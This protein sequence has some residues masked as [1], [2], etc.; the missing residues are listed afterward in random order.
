MICGKSSL[1][2]LTLPMPQ[3]LLYLVLV[4]GLE[5]ACMPKKSRKPPCRKIVLRL[6]DLDHTKSAVINSLSSPDSRR[7]YKFSME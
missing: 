2:S 6:P 3:G 7:N 4:S 5:A 1:R